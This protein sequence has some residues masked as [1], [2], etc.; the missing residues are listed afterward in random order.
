VGSLGPLGPAAIIAVRAERSTPLLPVTQADLDR[1][2]ALLEESGRRL[3]ELS[4]GLLTGGAAAELSREELATFARGL[5]RQAASWAVFTSILSHGLDLATAA[6]RGL[7]T[8]QF[9]R[10]ITAAV[11]EALQGAGT[12]ERAMTAM[13]AFA[14]GNVVEGALLELQSE[15]ERCVEPV[16]AR[17]LAAHRAG[18]DELATNLRVSVAVSAALFRD[19]LHLPDAGAELEAAAAAG[20]LPG[21]T[22]NTVLAALAKAHAASAPPAV[23]PFFEALPRAVAKGYTLGAAPWLFLLSEWVGQ[24]TP[25]CATL[26]QHQARAAQQDRLSEFI[27]LELPEEAGF[28]PAA[29]AAGGRVHDLLAGGPTPVRVFEVALLL[30]AV[31][32]MGQF[33]LMERDHMPLVLE[34]G[35]GTP[36]YF[37]VPHTVVELIHRLSERITVDGQ[38]PLPAL[39]ACL[40]QLFGAAEAQHDAVVAFAERLHND[41][42]DLVGALRPLAAALRA[43][44]ASVNNFT[45]AFAHIALRAVQLAGDDP[46]EGLFLA[47]AE[48]VDLALLRGGE[49]LFAAFAGRLVW[50]DTSLLVR[51]TQLEQ[52]VPRGAVALPTGEADKFPAFVEMLNSGADAAGFLALQDASAMELLAA[53]QPGST[54]R[55]ALTCPVTKAA[56]FLRPLAGSR[57][58]VAAAERGPGGLFAAVLR[59]A[60]AVVE[61]LPFRAGDA[62]VGA[63]RAAAGTAATGAGPLP[64][65]LAGAAAYDPAAAA[66]IA[67]VPAQLAQAT[68]TLAPMLPVLTQVMGRLGIQGEAADLPGVL[69]GLMAGMQPLRVGQAAGPAAGHHTGEYRSVTA[70]PPVRRRGGEE[71]VITIYCSRSDTPREGMQCRHGG[72][73]MYDHYSCCGQRE[74]DGPC[75]CQ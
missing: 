1:A 66:A 25:F 33:H 2:T 40:L 26:V 14:G 53:A 73:L 32:L 64:A 45:A 41:E 20:R 22:A 29:R 23:K 16:V 62:A 58:A 68:Q 30:L 12:A 19:V 72:L 5:K 44:E 11:G 60:V 74:E 43:N 57:A 21:A 35:L 10:R 34:P 46:I 67:G 65:L 24:V 13:M 28:G 8:T 55:V 31:Q 4:G 9:S 54:K 39:A 50:A 63:W 48:P 71:H 17:E 38:A 3:R 49:A 6:A 42:A 56:R 15:V 69:Q 18:E 36:T 52:Y 51:S 27:H 7:E 47:L 59:L 61:I 70:R 37:V 75:L